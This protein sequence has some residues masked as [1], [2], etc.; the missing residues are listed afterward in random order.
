VN[1]QHLTIGHAARLAGVT[2]KALRHY[3][4]IGLLRPAAVDPHN[5]Y[6]RYRPEQVVQARQIR[7][8]RELELTLDEIRRLLALG[9]APGTFDRDAFVAA[10]SAH[11]TRIEARAT[12][13][14]G[15]LHI[16]D[17]AITDH[18]WIT[19]S[20][21]EAPPV[22]DEKEI[23]R[24]WGRTLFNDV[25]R[26]MEKEDRT[27]DE[28]AQ[29]IHQA[30]ASVY[31]WSHVGT[32]ANSARGEWQCSRVYCVLRRPEPALYHARRVLDICQRNGIGD[33]D[34]AFAYEALARAFSVAG[35]SAETQRFLEQA[36]AAGRDI[37]EDDDRELLL[38]DLETVRVPGA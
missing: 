10:M 37:A 15:V 38:A 31:H 14:R 30:H 35:D 16:L 19:M 32:A 4:R 28:D 24:Y 34:L 6:R 13:L 11:R 7:R 8:L 2:T 25:W 23:H 3:D 21:P 12:R 26:L 1:E 29:M 22:G 5:G 9:E 17:H 33:W 18:D 36:R 20:E 27:P